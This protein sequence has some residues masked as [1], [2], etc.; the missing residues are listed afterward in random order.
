MKSVIRALSRLGYGILAVVVVSALGWVFVTY[1]SWIFSKTIRGEVLRN[2]RVTNP[3]A[4]F[5]GRA[6]TPEVMHSFT[7]LI[8]D[9]KTGEMHTASSEDRQWA[10]VAAGYCVSARFFPYPPWELEKGGTYGN[11][12]LEAVYDCPGGKKVSAEGGAPTPA[13]APA[14]APATSGPSAAPESR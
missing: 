5:G 12:R 14:E 9:E 2:E 13:P 10:V 8:R 1:Y 7:V 11:A 4:I 3:T 6:A